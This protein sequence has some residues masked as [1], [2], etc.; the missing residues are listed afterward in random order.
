MEENN[1]QKK[2]PAKWLFGLT[3]AASIG[4]IGAGVAAYQG[5]KSRK[6]QKRQ[7]REQQKNM[8]QI[9]AQKLAFQK[10]QQAK[11][12]AQK[13]EYRAME[14]INPYADF[15][16]RYSEVG[17]MYADLAGTMENTFEDMTV[18]QRAA[19]FQRNT[20]AQQSANILQ[21][22]QGVAGGSGIASLAQQ[23]ANQQQLTTS[24]ISADLAKQQ[25]QNQLLSAQQEARLQQQR[26][27]MELQGAQL[28]LR[29][30]TIAA[31]G[32]AMLQEA[33]MS[34]QA[35]LLGMQ[36]GSAIGANQALN[37]AQQNTLMAQNQ[38]NQMQLSNMQATAGIFNNLSKIDFTGLDFSKGISFS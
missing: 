38:A 10:E 20:L 19:D 28:G 5:Y 18:D 3:A 2:S 4:L 12:D 36:Y 37:Q 7:F 33:E 22:L 16:E 8:Q 9:E 1:L 25:R 14:F 21:N 34:R 26:A 17:G 11:L 23:L 31:G 32:E 24:R 6:Q 29:G 30:E 13:A 27:N 35:T 15:G